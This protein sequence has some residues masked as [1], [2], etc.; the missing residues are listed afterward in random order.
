MSPTK[1]GTQLSLGLPACLWDME[2]PCFLPRLCSGHL[3]WW[4]KKLLR[5]RT[6][7][8]V[9]ADSLL[10]QSIRRTINIQKLGKCVT[11]SIIMPVFRRNREI[12]QI[13]WHTVLKWSASGSNQMDL[14]HYCWQNRKKDVCKWKPVSSPFQFDWLPQMTVQFV[15]AFVF[16]SIVVLIMH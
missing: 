7:V 12:T 11:F 2:L 4:I 3:Y 10:N 9:L 5:K 8:S 16:A 15:Q 14:G 6:S 1:D 13:T